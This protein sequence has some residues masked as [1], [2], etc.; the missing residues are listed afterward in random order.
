MH[1]I[2]RGPKFLGDTKHNERR[3]N[4][5]TDNNSTI[6]V[7]AHGVRPDGATTAAGADEDE[8]NGGDSAGERQENASRAGAEQTAGKT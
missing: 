3:D 6:G 7:T 1:A 5:D 4:E 8:G 2:D